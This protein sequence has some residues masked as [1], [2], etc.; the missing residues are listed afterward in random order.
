MAG[1]SSKC[2]GA[3][4][5]HGFSLPDPDFKIT[6][7]EKIVD[8]Y[9]KL[10]AGA[11]EGTGQ[12]EDGVEEAAEQAVTDW[13]KEAGR[14][15]TTAERER[16]MNNIRRIHEG[17]WLEGAKAELVGKTQCPVGWFNRLYSEHEE[18]VRHLAEIHVRAAEQMN[19][20][21]E[22]I[23]ELEDAKDCEPFK[24]EV[25]TLKAEIEVLKLRPTTAKVDDSEEVKR[26]NARLE[27]ADK[28]KADL[29]RRIAELHRLRDQDRDEIDR[30]Q[31]ELRASRM[32]ENAVKDQVRTQDERIQQQEQ[33]KQDL[34][35]EI[36]RLKDKLD[37]SPVVV[38]PGPGTTNPAPNPDPKPDPTG[39]PGPIP[40][41]PIDSILKAIRDA[42]DNNRDLTEEIDA[43]IN[44]LM[45]LIGGKANLREFWTAVEEMQNNCNKLRKRV[46]ELYKHLG[47]SRDNI[48]AEEAIDEIWEKVSEVESDD[49]MKLK[50]LVLK[51][52][53]E[54]SMAEMRISTAEMKADT[55]QMKIDMEKT[56]LERDLEAKKQLDFYDDEELERRVDERVQM[57]REHRRLLIK[58]M[59]TAWNQLQLVIMTLPP[60]EA[61]VAATIEEIRSQYL[62]PALL[63][64]APA[65]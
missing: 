51:L 24:E 22:R 9:K 49:V 38:Q 11:L 59:M 34:R 46:L 8:F 45:A 14:S 33:D 4:E 43:I 21:R 55:L 15:A 10:P 28:E 20:L 65:M 58:N 2:T 62:S 25:R 36:D 39:G 37:E 17:S 57:Y 31:D 42:K 16:M 35:D 5:S 44:R 6:D 40:N 60:T 61:A 50:L 23:E 29:E 48:T 47:F 13:E 32:R 26:L 27:E 7:I 1:S 41:E 54:L 18:S 30:L 19:E 12:W 52:T 64:P 3:T 53:M 63:P 56:D